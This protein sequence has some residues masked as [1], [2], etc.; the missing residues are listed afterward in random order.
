VRN[1]TRLGR[2]L[3]VVILAAGLGAPHPGQA[4]RGRAL[5][6]DSQFLENIPEPPPCDVVIT[7]AN[8]ATTLPMLNDPSKYVFCISPGN[9]LARGQIALRTQGTSTRRRYFRYNGS[10]PTLPAIRQTDRVRLHGLLINEASWWVVEGITVQPTTQDTSYLV[11]I[12]GSSNNVLQGNLIDASLQSNYKFQSGIVFGATGP[13]S[14]DP[15][16]PSTYNSI[17]RNVIRGGNKSRLPVDYAGVNIPVE[18]VA[19][20]NNDYNKILDNEI[21]DWGDGIQVSSSTDVCSSY[22]AVPRGTLIDNNDIYITSAKRVRCSDGAPDPDGE[23]SCSENGID[24]KVA[25][26]SNASRWTRVMNNRLWGFRPTLRDAPSCGGSG[27]RGQAITSGN[28]CAGYVFVARNTIMDSTVGIITQGQEWRVVGNLF[29]EIR[30]ADVSNGN[31]GV[32]IYPLEQNDALIQFNTMV[33]TDNAYSD[34][35]WGVVTQC[36]AV[37]HDAGVNGLQGARGSP[38]TTRYNHTYESNTP[39]IMVGSTN[40]AHPNDI[41]S[42]NRELCFHRKRWTESEEVCI[43][44]AETV[45]GSPHATLPT[46]CSTAIGVDFGLP[47]VFFP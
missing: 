11:A 34:S 19:G 43:P 33:A 16:T 39:D 46:A 32:A 47:T 41:Q 8:A 1:F 3:A 2:T 22:V 24:I 23:C 13:A 31:R 25:P 4:G 45:Q 28:S 6:Q 5:F 40:V 12:F 17:Q 29:H 37:V 10:W 36:N 7:T 38:H 21:Y 42:Q 35:G 30:T 14:A 44:F 20:A 15:G 9:Y 27:S 26:G 18:D